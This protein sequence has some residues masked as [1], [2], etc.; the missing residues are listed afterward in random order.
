MDKDPPAA[1]AVIYLIFGQPG[2]S[3]S[4]LGPDRI[5]DDARHTAD[6][7]HLKRVSGKTDRTAMRYV[8]TAHPERRPTFPR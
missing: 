8:S 7:V 6:H 4:K 3:P 5:L 2:I 1:R